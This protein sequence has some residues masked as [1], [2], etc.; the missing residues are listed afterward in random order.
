MTILRNVQFSSMLKKIFRKR[1]SKNHPHALHLLNY[2]FNLHYY[3]LCHYHRKIIKS[4]DT[5]E[6]QTQVNYQ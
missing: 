5:F 3:H 2:V 4:L 6:I 1:N